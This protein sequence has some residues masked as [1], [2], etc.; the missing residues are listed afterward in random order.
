MREGGRLLRGARSR[1]RMATVIMRSVTS[2]ACHS[3]EAMTAFS[4]TILIVIFY[5]A[6]SGVLFV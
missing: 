6:G 3:G 5:L 1:D 2:N 4:N